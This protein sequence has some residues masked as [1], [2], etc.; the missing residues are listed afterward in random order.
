MRIAHLHTFIW[1]SVDYI[2]T[3][4]YCNIFIYDYEIAF[5]IFFLILTCAIPPILMTIFGILTVFN[6]KKL[7][8][9]VGPQNN[10]ARNERLRSKDR[11]LIIMLLIQVLMT[12]LCTLPFSVANITSMIFQYLITLSDYGDAINTFY[13]NLSRLINYFNP[14]VGFYIY[15]L[16]SKTFR[17]EMKCM[18][19]E[20][21]KFILT[22]LGLEKF[23][24]SQREQTGGTMVTK[25]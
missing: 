11:Q 1:W 6:V 4:T 21:I 24:P 3:K 5:Q 19:M 7:R 23:I 8:T 20:A 2:G 25:A 14:V 12:I 10:D 16:S 22:K 18:F 15:T 17:S 9:Q 13:S